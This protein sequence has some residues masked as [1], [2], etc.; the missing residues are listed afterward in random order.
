[1]KNVYVYVLVN[2]GHNEEVLYMLK[3]EFAKIS[4]KE[5]IKYT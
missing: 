1:M 5:T 2:R 3:K 4:N